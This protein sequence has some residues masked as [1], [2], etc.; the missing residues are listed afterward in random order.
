MQCP[1]FLLENSAVL[2]LVIDIVGACETWA[3]PSDIIPIGSELD[4]KLIMKCPK[5]KDKLLT[6]FNKLLIITVLMRYFQA[7]VSNETTKGKMHHPIK[8]FLLAAVP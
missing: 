2:V 6:Y 7:H 8:A 1:P 5:A 3:K 4:V